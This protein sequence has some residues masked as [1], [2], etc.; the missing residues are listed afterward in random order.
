MFKSSGQTL[1][2]RGFTGKWKSIVGKSEEKRT[3]DYM[4]INAPVAVDFESVKEV[5]INTPITAF[6]RQKTSLHRGS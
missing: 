4:K 5:V 3:I 2:N 6:T 1:P